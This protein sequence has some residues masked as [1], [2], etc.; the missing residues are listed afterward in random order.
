MLNPPAHHRRPRLWRA[1]IVW[2]AMALT[3]VAAQAATMSDNLGDFLGTYTGP[4]NG[5]LD[6]LSVTAVQDGTN[7]TLTALL[8]G[9]PESTS[10]SAYVWGVNRGAG[11]EGLFT[12][13]TPVGQGVFFDAV[14]LIQASGARVVNI[15]GSTFNL[16]ANAVSISGD[17]LSVTVPFADL[18]STGFTTAAYLYNLWPRSGLGS[19][20]QIADFAP[21]A[22]SF[23][24]GV[25]EPSTWALLMLGF[26]GAG[27]LLRRRRAAALA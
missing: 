6:V 16:A 1:A 5:D 17:T 13:A 27:A 7:V 23:A 11:T 25:P 20:A 18:P 12:G 2:A 9:V 21:N 15:G 10:G 8:N 19:N 14:V 4:T 3:P 22:S 24:A 26:G